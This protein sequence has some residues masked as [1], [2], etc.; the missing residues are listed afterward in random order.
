MPEECGQDG[1]FQVAPKD[2]DA[3]RVVLVGG[4][5]FASLLHYQPCEVLAW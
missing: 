5:G 4:F 1:A 3:F 2:A